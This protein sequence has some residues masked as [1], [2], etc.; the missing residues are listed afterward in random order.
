MR[1]LEHRNN[2][3][4]WNAKEGEAN[5]RQAAEFAAKYKLAEPG[6]WAVTLTEGEGWIG[7][8]HV[9]DVM[10]ATRADGALVVWISDGTFAQVVWRKH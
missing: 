4:W 8:G 7:A 1:L 3:P 5:S 10:S 9:R 6:A 2:V